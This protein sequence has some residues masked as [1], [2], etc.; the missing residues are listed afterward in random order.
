[1]N[2]IIFGATGGL[3]QWTW[4]AAVRAGHRVTAFVRSPQKL[5]APPQGHDELRVVQGDVMDSEAVRV[6]SEGCDVAINCTSPA[7]GNSTLEMAQSIVGAAAASGVTRFYMV[8]GM[9]ALWAPGTAKS[10]LVQDWDDADAM[11]EFGIPSNHRR[12]RTRRADRPPCVRGRR[13]RA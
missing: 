3:G 1:M 2:I 4:K 12:S 5:D 10:V 8:G 7:A 6:A 11:A 9:G 13:L